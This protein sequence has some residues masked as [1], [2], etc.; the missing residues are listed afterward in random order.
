MAKKNKLTPEMVYKKNQ[1]KVK[2]FKNLTPIVYWLFLGLSV[3]FFLLMI[4]NSVG[5]ITEII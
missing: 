2:V 3:M 4:E 5:N 1:Q